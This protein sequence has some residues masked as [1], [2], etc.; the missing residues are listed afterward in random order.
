MIPLTVEQLADVVGGDLTDPSAGGRAI[1]G[2]VIDSRAAGPGALFAAL[3]GQRTDGHAHVGAA[4][5]AGAVACLV[6]TERLVDPA[7]ATA[8]D[9]GG[10]AVA[11]DEVGDALLGL[12]RWARDTV[13]PTVVCVTGSSGKTTT[14]D[15]IAAATGAGRSVVANVGSYNNELGV[16]LTCC[17]LELGSE[18]LVAEVG[19]RGLGH[20][21]RLA[22]LLA[23]DI[24]VVTTISGAHL[25][26]FGD[27]E[28]VARAKGELVEALGAG[29]L[30]VLNADDP[31]VAALAAR[32][33]G[34]VV[35]YGLDSEA[36]WRADDVELDALARARF[37]V[38]G[39]R[40]E[41]PLAGVHQVGN[42]L[43][44]LVVADA[45]GVPLDAAAA[46]LAAAPVSRWR[47]EVIRTAQGVVVVNDA[48]N[49]NPASTEA[50]LRTLAAVDTTGRRWAVLGE[51]A[52]LGPTSGDEHERVGRLAVRLGLDGVVAVGE[53]AERVR[54]G[55]AEEAAGRGEQRAVDDAQ[56]A[57]GLL[58]QRLEPG[59]VVLVKASRSAGLERL[60][61]QLVASLGG[62][63]GAP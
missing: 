56:A 51:M 15:L 9:E 24:A 35:T 47:S 21:A 13:D 11:V 62:A 8:L 6:A 33:V 49:A 19:A 29:G 16:P 58:A 10:A 26:Q 43:A 38:R 55:A 36:A 30:A 45:V 2:V 50:A 1:T 52:E 61:E 48:Y 5:R 7:V 25:E 27:L 3:P 23:P 40:V 59:D 37:T 60:A 46:A 4:A 32:T 42:A 31:R 22:A 57:A 63:E 12:G 54:H 18:V 39:V 14:K 17:R 53:P 34:R 44:A 28:T 41:L 20:V